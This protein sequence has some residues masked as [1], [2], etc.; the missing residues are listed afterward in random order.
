M[1][2]VARQLRLRRAEV[3]ERVVSCL[4][5][6]VVVGFTLVELLVVIAIIAILAALLLPVLGRAKD[7]AKRTA[8]LNNTRQLGIGT[9][10]YADDNHGKLSGTLNYADDNANW[11]Y[12]FVRA[13]KVFTC[14]STQHV[15]RDE[16]KEPSGEYSDL[17][18]FAKTKNGFGHSYEQFGWWANA[19]GPAERKT[20]SLVMTRAKKTFAFG[21][22]RKVPGPSATW[23]MVDGDDVP[24]S[25]L[26]NYPD[27]K[28]NHG[29]AG[30]NAVFC[31]GHAEWVA[32]RDYI[33]TYELSQD[34]GI[35]E[36]PKL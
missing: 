36:P 1:S 28:D 30:A 10:L 23:L 24:P 2:P 12:P 16:K 14:P 8:C 31:D 32:Q 18:D 6:R 21:M 35:S 11:L 34:E 22:L 9:Q 5:S 19:P 27:A 26:N 15:V 17:L 4:P 3:G 13:T 29:A 33:K 7:K 20:E 25:L